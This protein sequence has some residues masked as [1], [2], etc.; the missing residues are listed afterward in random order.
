MWLHIRV[1]ESVAVAMT[2][3]NSQNPEVAYLVN[4]VQLPSRESV[5]PEVVAAIGPLPYFSMVEVGQM[6]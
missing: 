3:Y 4:M 2:T 6:I 5:I 1:E